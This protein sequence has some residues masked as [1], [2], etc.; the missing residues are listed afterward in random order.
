MYRFSTYKEQYKA[1]LKLALPVVLT[2]LGQVLVQFADNLMVGRYGGSDPLPLAAVSFGSS[3]FFIFFIAAVGITFGLTPL[4]GE[5]YAQGDRKRSSELLQSGLVLYFCIGLLTAGLLYAITPLLYHMGQPRE[6]VDMAIPYYRMVLYGMPFAMLFFAFKQFLEGVG[7]TKVEMV[8]TI[9]CNTLN[10]GLNWVFIYGHCGFREMG[11]E[12]AG[13]ATLLSRALLPFLMAGYVLHR[14]RYRVYLKGFT[15]LRWVRDDMRTLLRMGIPISSQMFLEGSAFV[16]TGVMMGWLGTEAISANQITTTL[17]NCAFMIVMSI[18][19]ATTI[20]VSHCFGARSLP[21]LTLAAKASYHLAIA[22]NLFAAAMFILLRHSIPTLFTEN[23]QVIA[24]TADLLV[25]VALFQLSDGI[26]NV[27]V[28]ILRGV[29]DVKVIMPIALLAYW[30]L[31]LP[32]GYLC[33][34]TLGMGP[35]GLILGF[36]FGLSMAGLL[37]IRRIRKRV[38][39]LRSQWSADSKAAVGN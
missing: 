30:C 38:R 32:V 15:P 21:E 11:A 5:L 36:T 16:G 10:V 18:G 1:N 35:E 33:G 14:E 25:F 6:V 9:L 8:A 24:L 19:A 27:S 3:V 2:Q 17:A 28:G 7:N 22:W 37:M 26:Q 13:L 12:G 31:N 23:A 34:F 39:Q 4:I 20:R 29:Q